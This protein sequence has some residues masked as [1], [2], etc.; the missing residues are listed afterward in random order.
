MT[1]RAHGG[2]LLTTHRVSRRRQYPLS[3]RV[4]NSIIVSDASSA[5]PNPSNIYITFYTDDGEALSNASN[6]LMPLGWAG[7]ALVAR[8]CMRNPR[9]RRPPSTTKEAFGFFQIPPIP[10][11]PMRRARRRP[12]PLAAV[13]I[14]AMSMLVCAKSYTQKPLAQR[15][16]EKVKVDN[17][18]RDR[19]DLAPAQPLPVVATA[20]LP[21]AMPTATPVAVAPHVLQTLP[22]A[23]PTHVV[24]GYTTTTTVI[25]RQG[26]VPVA[27]AVAI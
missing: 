7:A 25:S 19:R 24:T 20:S 5:P 14:C 3:L 27:Q 18:V 23:T 26:A 17:F 16:V 22:V 6:I 13:V 15:P 4:Y 2:P 1:P 12:A 21:V 8:P 11:T 10:Y 9:R